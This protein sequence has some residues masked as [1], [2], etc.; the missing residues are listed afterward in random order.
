MTMDRKDKVKDEFTKKRSVRPG[1][2]SGRAKVMRLG[3]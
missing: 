1:D 2:E 3:A